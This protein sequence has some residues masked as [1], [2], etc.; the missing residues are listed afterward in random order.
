VVESMAGGARGQ[1]WRLSI[2]QGDV[3]EVYGTGFPSQRE[4]ERE[5]GESRGRRRSLQA[6]VGRGSGGG[7]QQPGDEY[8][9]GQHL[10]VP[11]LASARERDGEQREGGRE[12]EGAWPAAATSQARASARRGLALGNYRSRPGR[13]PVRQWR[14][15]QR[16]RH[17]GDRCGSGSGR[18]ALWPVRLRAELVRGRSRGGA[19]RRRGCSLAPVVLSPIRRL[20]TAA[21]AAGRLRRQRDLGIGVPP[22]RA[23]GVHGGEDRRSDVKMIKSLLKTEDRGGAKYLTRFGHCHT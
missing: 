9:T 2:S 22:P 15:R 16:L 3:A 1:T 5:K 7:R 17:G 10:P 8:G 23:H 4:S 21:A 12:T 19:R 14:G 13:S 6:P 18:R 20:G 11:V